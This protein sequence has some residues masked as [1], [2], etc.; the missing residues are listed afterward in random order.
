M[1]AVTGV[2]GPP[3][4]GTEYT[5]KMPVSLDEKRTRFSSAENDAPLTDVVAMNCSMV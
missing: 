2:A 3:A 4:T 5:L 1:E